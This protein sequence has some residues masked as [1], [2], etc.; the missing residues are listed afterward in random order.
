MRAGGSI[1]IADKRAR[2]KPCVRCGYSLIRLADARNCPECGLAVRVT[3]AGNKGLEW[4]NPGWQRFLAFAFALLAV[5]FFCKMLASAA[6]W[7]SFFAVRSDHR[8]RLG[9]LEILYRS[10]RWL[11]IAWTIISG[12][13]L[14]LMSRHER[15]YPDQS[16]GFRWLLLA[17][18]IAS[19]TLGA[20]LALIEAFAS[21]ATSASVRYWPWGLVA[22]PWPS[23]VVALLSCTLSRI[24][25][26]R[27]HSRWLQKISQVSIWVVAAATVI[28]LWDITRFFWP[29][30]SIVL[31]WLFPLSMITMCVMTIRVLR[32]GARE[33]TANWVSDP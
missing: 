12:L 17:A 19:V 21:G 23:V 10:R 9:D 26:R 33:A 13:A 22:D 2:L 4:S 5:G 29:L 28:W 1:L 31:H 24:L 3:L 25:A 7:V 18:G 11:T 15:R 32:I 27:G 16:R 30:R 20:A 6:D 8:L 14:C